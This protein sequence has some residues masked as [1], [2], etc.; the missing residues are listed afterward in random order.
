VEGADRDS[1]M[2]EVYHNCIT[3]V[4]ARGR[5]WAGAITTGRT[6]GTVGCG[7]GTSACL[8]DRIAHIVVFIVA[9]T[10]YR[11]LVRSG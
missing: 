7:F 5:F 10:R 9:P 4:L 6:I 3:D 1:S 8:E 11:R 2:T